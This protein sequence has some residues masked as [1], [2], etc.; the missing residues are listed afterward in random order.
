MVIPGLSF[1]NSV[2][3][4][5]MVARLSQDMKVTTPLPVEDPEALVPLPPHA[6]TEAISAPATTAAPAILNLISC[7]RFL[8]GSSPRRINLCAVIDVPVERTR[9]GR[10]PPRGEGDPQRGG[11]RDD[12]VD[13]SARPMDQPVEHKLAMEAVAI[14]DGEA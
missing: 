3:R 14:G 1:S 2:I 11:S 12:L 10:S 9:S 4:G 5:F 13:V 7:S 6:A 8:A